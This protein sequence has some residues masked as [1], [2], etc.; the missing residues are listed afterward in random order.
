MANLRLPLLRPS[1]E[2]IKIRG[3]LID[4][5]GKSTN[6]PFSSDSK[7]LYHLTMANEDSLAKFTQYN[8]LWAKTKGVDTDFED[9]WDS[10]LLETNKE[11]LRKN[12][13]RLIQGPQI[14]ESEIYECFKCHSRLITTTKQQTRA[15]DEET[16]VFYKCNSCGNAWKG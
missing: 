15:A 3:Y 14:T 7:E 6:K 12:I 13:H 1:V 5:L 9:L 10:P 11:E 4:C 16:D 2:E 8:R